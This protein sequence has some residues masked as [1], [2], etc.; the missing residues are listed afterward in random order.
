MKS[1]N[2]ALGIA[3]TPPV[4]SMFESFLDVFARH[5]TLELATLPLSKHS[6]L[7]AQNSVLIS[8]YQAIALCSCVKIP[9]SWTSTETRSCGARQ[10]AAIEKLKGKFTVLMEKMEGADISTSTSS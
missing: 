7:T 3:N 10:L 1:T 8:V 6:A 4:C 9:A 2:Q 5:H